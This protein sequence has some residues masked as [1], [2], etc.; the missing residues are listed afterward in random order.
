MEHVYAIQVMYGGG[1]GGD[2]PQILVGMCRGKVKN[3]GGGGGG[4]R[5][6]LERE[7]GSPELTVGRVWL[8]LWPAANPGVSRSWAA[9]NGVK[10][11]YGKEISRMMVSGAVKN[12]K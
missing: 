1:G 8:A 6:E 2:S 7:L 9:M 3:G 4:L 12:V 10:F 11:L 5:S